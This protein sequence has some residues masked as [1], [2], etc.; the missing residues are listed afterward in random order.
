MRKELKD[1]K[2]RL[3]SLLSEIEELTVYAAKIVED[4]ESDTII[5]MQK[6]A[7]LEMFLRIL[8][9]LIWQVKNAKDGEDINRVNVILQQQRRYLKS[10]VLREYY[11]ERWR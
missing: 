5:S 3:L 2:K 7:V 11:P 10:D 4:C 1:Y 8:P 9:R 6:Q